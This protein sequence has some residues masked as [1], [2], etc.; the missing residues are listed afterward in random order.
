MSI[1]ILLLK[2]QWVAERNLWCVWTKQRTTTV[3][4][5]TA[6]K[7]AS[8]PDHSLPNRLRFPVLYTV[9]R[10]SRLI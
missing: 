10:F 4:F 1:N 6:W 3:F 7:L 9:H 2:Y 8:F 5:G